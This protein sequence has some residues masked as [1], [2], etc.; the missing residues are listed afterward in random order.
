MSYATMA[1]VFVA[2][3]CLVAALCLLPTWPPSMRWR[4][5]VGLVALTLAVL[6]A[7]FDSVMIAADLFRY[8]ESA[9]SGVRVLL[10]PVEDFAWPLAAAVLLPSL[11]VALGRRSRD[12]GPTRA[13]APGAGTADGPAGDRAG[14]RR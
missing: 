13:G 3:A 10:A 11:W 14:E 8:D 7:V 4:G 6:T 9:L 2:G 1:L 12:S 5:A